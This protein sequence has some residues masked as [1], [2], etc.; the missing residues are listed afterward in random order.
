MKTRG[1]AVANP[2]AREVWRKL[3]AEAGEEDIELVASLGVE[4]V[5]R[6]LAAYGF[7]VAAERGKGEAFLAELAGE[8]E[9]SGQRPVTAA[10]AVENVRAAR[11]FDDER[12]RRPGAMAFVIATVAA[13]AAGGVVY[14]LTHRAPEPPGPSPSPSPSPIAPSP[15]EAPQRDLVAA[16]LRRKAAASCDVKR[17]AEC[18]EWLDEAKKV[19]PAGDEAP[20]ARGLRERAMRGVGEKPEGKDKPR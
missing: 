13:A 5:E 12:R 20:E 18:L 3:V 8:P 6:E 14:E 19:D 9:A 2:S 11:R 7:D 16:D 4:D 17:W 1:A 15:V 10:H